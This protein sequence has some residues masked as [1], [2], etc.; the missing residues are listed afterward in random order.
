[1]GT[2]SCFE[3]SVPDRFTCMSFGK[4]YKN[5]KLHKRFDHG[6]L[7]VQYNVENPSTNVFTSYDPQA[8]MR[9]CLPQGNLSLDK[10]LEIYGE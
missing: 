7:T 5:L 3:Q 6:T 9:S 8:L 4:M 2:T 1:M 10:E